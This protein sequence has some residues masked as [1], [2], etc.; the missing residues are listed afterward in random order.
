MQW[1]ML[2]AIV[3]PDL[4]ER[5]EHRLRDCGVK[6]ISVTAVKGYGECADFFRRDWMVPHA[7]IEIFTAMGRARGIAEEIMSAAHTGGQGDGIVAILPVGQVFRV[8]ER[9]PC[10]PDE[11]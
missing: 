11:I 10:E 6:G 7:R 8:R 4:L 5:V 2:I 9:C 3:R 1:E